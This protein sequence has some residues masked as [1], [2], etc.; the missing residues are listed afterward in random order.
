MSR[1][2]NIIRESELDDEQKEYLIECSK[3]LA[4]I[5]G[6][7]LDW[8]GFI[9]LSSLLELYTIFWEDGFIINSDKDEE[10]L[11]KDEA[12]TIAYTLYKGDK[13]FKSMDEAKWAIMNNSKFDEDQSAYFLGKIVQS[14]KV[15]LVGIDPYNIKRT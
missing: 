9:T 7:D 12:A 14:H 8:Q 6:D 11:S 15:S 1:H 10:D 4:K 13:V 5:F 3:R 2:L